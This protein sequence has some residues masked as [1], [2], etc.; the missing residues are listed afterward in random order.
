[1]YSKGIPAHLEN[2]IDKRFAEMQ[3]RKVTSITKRFKYGRYRILYMAVLKSKDKHVVVLRIT[4]W[5]DQSF[6]Y[7]SDFVADNREYPQLLKTYKHEENIS[8]TK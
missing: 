2:E 1:M 7:Y 5:N 3:K 6:N 4:D 8:D